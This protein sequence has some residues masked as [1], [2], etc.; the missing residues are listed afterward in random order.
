[1]PGTAAAPLLTPLAATVTPVPPHPLSA[2]ERHAV[3]TVPFDAQLETRPASLRV[4]SGARHPNRECSLAALP[5]SAPQSTLTS[6]NLT[7]LRRMFGPAV[8]TEP[9]VG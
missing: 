5:R 6:L 1:M 2:G 4:R 9:W 3:S 7:P 8:R